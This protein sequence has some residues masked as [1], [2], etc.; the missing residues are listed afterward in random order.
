[1]N[2]PQEVYDLAQLFDMRTQEGPK[3]VDFHSTRN[4]HLRSGHASY[5]RGEP[6]TFN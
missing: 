1:M 4:V 3:H 5:K 6:I 2:V